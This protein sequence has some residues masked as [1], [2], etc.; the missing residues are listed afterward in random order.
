MTKNLIVSKIF[1]SDYNFKNI[2]DLKVEFL[3]P[4]RSLAYYLGSKMCITLAD[5]VYIIIITSHIYITTRSA[6]ITDIFGVRTIY[7]IASFLILC[8]ACLSFRLLKHQRLQKKEIS[9]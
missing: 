3:L 5:I 7:I 4:K 2:I 6:T 8:S 9:I 1:F